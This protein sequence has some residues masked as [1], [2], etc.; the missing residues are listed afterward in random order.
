M[1]VRTRPA[2]VAP[3]SPELNWHRIMRLG[4]LGVVSDLRDRW[5]D[6]S[7]RNRPS[8]RALDPQ[9]R[10]PV[11]IIGAPRSGTTFL[12]N[13]LGRLPGISYHFEPRLTKA[14]A[15]C[16]YDGSW[17][18]RRGAALFRLSYG[19]LLLATLDGGHRFAEKNPE[20]SFLVPFLAAQFPDAQFVHII[21]D[22]R[23]ATVSHAEQPWLAAAS[24]TSGQRGAGG[25][26]HG[27]SA[28]WWVEPQRR[29]EFS[30][31]PDIVRS[32]W[33]WRRFTESALEGVAGLADRAAE[34]RYEGMVGNP[35]ATADMLADFLDLSLAG[36]DRLHE[37]LTRVRT[38]SVGR[39][40]R[41]LGQPELADV[42]AE[43]GPLLSRLGYAQLYGRQAPDQRRTLAMN[44]RSRQARPRL[45]D[46]AITL[47]GKTT[48]D[49]VPDTAM[50]T[51]RVWAEGEALGQFIYRGWRRRARLMARWGL[52]TA[53]RPL[54]WMRMMPSFLI[55]GAERC[56][57]TSMFDVLRQHPAVFSS[58]LPRKE[59]HYFDHMY[60]HGA[61][62]YQCHFPLIPRA[63]LAVRGA[64]NPVAFE[65]TPNYM[66]H[67]LAPARI[68][69]QLPDVRLLVMVRDP[70][71]R[72]YSAH[73]HQVGF[74]YETEPFERAVF[75][76]EDERLRGEEER[77]IADPSYYS[78]NHSH[79]TYRARGYYADQLER[80]EHLFGRDRI[81]VV[82]VGDFCA[83]PEPVY[84]QILDFLHLPHR[85]LPVFR[86]QNVR[87][88]SPMPASLRTTLEEHF[89]PH[90]ERLAAWL[91]RE[92]SWRR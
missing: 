65:G 84:E 52:L 68:H 3:Q 66:F 67:P 18:T 60:R 41:T 75:E 36:R 2:A 54:Y 50:P 33:C 79:Y 42:L 10:R 90:D 46:D 17:S 48:P 80:L 88:R 27:P 85:G 44:S 57:T 39:W 55:A 43:I 14:A 24:A 23:D 61:A 81:H 58:T 91:G 71:E 87:P 76:L 83:S 38:D 30:Q 56:G 53:G 12:G 28:R 77:I 21:R 74:G 5:H 8:L 13:C 32:A 4:A 6:P 89:R 70:V 9:P 19:S 37:G 59:V 15:R 64:G 78:F 35:A 69:R 20:N 31:V 86:R 25:Q 47:D 72:A 92:P 82:D 26:L 51:Q 45:H 29:E 62:W 63:R 73:A 7:L 34:V 40:R 49:A 16:V 1:T 11:F 22:G